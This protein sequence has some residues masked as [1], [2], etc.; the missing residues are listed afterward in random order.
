ETAAPA[1]RRDL[2]A[3]AGEVLETKLNNLQAAKELYEGVLA[4]D[5]GHEKA[6]T[7][8]AA[9]C[10]KVDDKEGYV[11]ALERRASYVG[12]EQKQRALCQI[13]EAYEEQLDD[14]AKAASYFEAALAENP[15]N[16]D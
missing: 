3:E 9:L 5:P 12:G 11:Q 4:E 15:D 7:N 13:A 8:L 16:L 2:Q 10:L 6:A 14:L 1:I